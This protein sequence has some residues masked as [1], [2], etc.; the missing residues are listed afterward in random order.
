MDYTIVNG[1]LYHHGVKG[2]KWGHRK[3]KS[4]TSKPSFRKQRKSLEKEYGDLED[5][6]TYGKK[7]D[8]KKNAQIQKKMTSIENKLDNLSKQERAA[9]AEKGR[10]LL[11]K[12]MSSAA[13]GMAAMGTRNMGFGV[14]TSV[15]VGALEKQRVKGRQE[16][17]EEYRKYYR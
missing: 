1:E 9:K 4:Q 2:M 8:H 5:Q 16:I 6:M 10:K 15:A 17:Y 12:I 13:A 3:A 14:G 7:A 11:P